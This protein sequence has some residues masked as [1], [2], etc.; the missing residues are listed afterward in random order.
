MNDANRRFLRGM[1]MG[2]DFRQ[3]V[4]RRAGLR[5]RRLS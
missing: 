4:S 5:A 1:P 2:K 3:S